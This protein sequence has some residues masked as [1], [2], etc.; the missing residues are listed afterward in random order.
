MRAPIAL[1]LLTVISCST[2]VAPVPFDRPDE[3]EAYYAAKRAGAA[4]PHA[5]YAAA[6]AQM[7]KMQSFSTAA[8][9]TRVFDPWTFLGPGNIGGRTRTLVI[10]P[11]TYLYAGAVVVAAG[12]LSALIVRNRIDNLDLVGVLKTR[13]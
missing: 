12:V 3:A 13:E 2:Y 8:A 1:L 9:E 5:K 11:R 4:D 10:D 6:R 7:A